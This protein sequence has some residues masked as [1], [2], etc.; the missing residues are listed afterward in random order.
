MVSKNVLNYLE[1]AFYSNISTHSDCTDVGDYS[2]I[3]NENPGTLASHNCTEDSLP[4]KKDKGVAF[5]L[6]M[7]MLQALHLILLEYI[8][9]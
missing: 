6:L 8:L 5:S 3:R 2:C 1:N 4:C 7:I 9:S